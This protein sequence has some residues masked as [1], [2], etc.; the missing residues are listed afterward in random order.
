MIQMIQS[1]NLDIPVPPRKFCFVQRKNK[2]RASCECTAIIDK[3]RQIVYHELVNQKLVCYDY[4]TKRMGFDCFTA[5]RKN[6]AN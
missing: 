5:E 3:K 1:E 4:I 2:N 6:Y